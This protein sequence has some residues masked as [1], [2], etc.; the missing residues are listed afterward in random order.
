MMEVDDEKT[1]AKRKDLTLEEKRAL[2][3]AKNERRLAKIA[4]QGPE[5]EAAAQ[6]RR[7]RI[8]QREAAKRERN[9]AKKLGQQWGTDAGAA[10][11]SPA[12][13]G[14]VKRKGAREEAT[15]AKKKAKSDGEPPTQ[16]NEDGAEGAN[17]NSGPASQPP[18]PIERDNGEGGGGAKKAKKIKKKNKGE[19]AAAACSKAT[20]GAENAPDTPCAGA[21]PS[22]QAIIA[23]RAS[24]LAAAQRTRL[25][26]PFEVF[27]KYLPPNATEDQVCS[28]FDGCGEMEA[29]GPKL[30][31][32]SVSGRV[33]RGFVTFK[34]PQACREALAR[35][36]EKLGKRRVE[37]TVATTTGT[38]QAEGTHTPAMFAECIKELGVARFPNGV[39]VDGTFG[40]GGHTRKVL[41][42]LGPTGELH[43]FDMDEEAVE[44]GRQL[45][46]EDPRFHMH[47]APF[48]SMCQV[49]TSDN[50][51]AGR[52]A[53]GFKA[54]GGFVHGVL[55][56]IGISSPQLDGGRGFRP[57]FDGPLDMR[58]DQR[59]EVEDAL[60]FLKRV[61]RHELAAVVE[62]YGGEHPLTARRIADAVALA[63]LED[64]LPERTGAF[65]ALVSAA[66]GKEYQAMHPAKMTFQALR[67]QVNREYE[68][69][70]GGLEASAGLLR[71]GGKTCILTWK[72]T[73]CAIVVDFARRFE[74]AAPGAPLRVW[75]DKA[76][77]G[78]CTSG[79]PSGG[80][81]GKKKAEKA[82]LA[83]PAKRLGVI[84][85]EAQRPTLDEVKKNSR[86]R[87]AVLHILRRETG[88]RM[89]DL[90]DRAGAWFSWAPYTT[91][92]TYPG[93][94]PRPT[95]EPGI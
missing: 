94:R 30:M 84:V 92:G 43:A 2:A 82:L 83:K 13:G 33:I 85:E 4:A 95:S 62:A 9:K 17:P 76:R 23:S 72:H 91:E 26:P 68:E 5:A 11:G 29:P 14:Q 15:Q 16:K 61:G 7:E 6:L 42:A 12:G 88:V 18:L 80:G 56:D 22:D 19:G 3:A 87:S 90:E 50:V 20:G 79:G 8:A 40:R 21:N 1:K 51:V 10:Q 47:H 75:F 49:L 27:L 93:G 31:R 65:A 60:G 36:L 35:S 70:R 63:K 28:F 64:Q 45:E 74:I 24:Q 25:T 55:I 81:Q 46:K 58:F 32:D 38:M 53:K 41:E 48:S 77:K 69:L 67:I 44:V 78:D 57:E 73:E 39:F 71:D 86:S 34:T 54:G 59:P 37:V 52:E 66:K 89:S